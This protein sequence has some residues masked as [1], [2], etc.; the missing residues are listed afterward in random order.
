MLSHLDIMN[1]QAEPV[2]R[3]TLYL[4]E[5]LDTKL[6]I[7]AAMQRVS[8]NEL[9]NTVLEKELKDIDVEGLQQFV[10]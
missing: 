4:A 1:T 3:K 8:V 7:K 5:T 6:R 10:S 2:R 9:I